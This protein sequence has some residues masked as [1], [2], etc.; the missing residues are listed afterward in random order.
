MNV[1]AWVCSNLVDPET[2][3][4]DEDPFISTEII[5]EDR[6]QHDPRYRNKNWN[7]WIDVT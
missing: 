4:T 3:L 6:Y 1:F 7:G 5:P 2:D